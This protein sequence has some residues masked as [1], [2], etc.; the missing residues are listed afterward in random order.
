VVVV[1]ADLPDALVASV[2]RVVAAQSA[3]KE[4]E[5]KTRT[6][7]LKADENKALASTVTTQSLEYQRNEIMKAA[8]EN[9]SIQKMVIINGAKMD[10]FPGSLGEK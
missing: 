4:Q 8:F 1:K 10:F 2:N 5:V 6:A 9:G 7:Q 3:N